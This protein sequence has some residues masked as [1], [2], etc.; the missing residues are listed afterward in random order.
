MAGRDSSRGGSFSAGGSWR[1]TLFSFGMALFP[2]GTGEFCLA[3]LPGGAFD[4]R[5]GVCLG[6]GAGSLF[7]SSDGGG[8]SRETAIGSWGLAR[9]GGFPHRKSK[10]R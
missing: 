6:A 4:G 9:I 10:S 3:I 2:R 7:A 5:R 8:G 1:A